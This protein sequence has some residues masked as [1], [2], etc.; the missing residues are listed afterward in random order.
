ME[1]ISTG[2]ESSSG[3]IPAAVS[4]PSELRGRLILATIM[5]LTYATD[6]VN[7]WNTARA[8]RFVMVVVVLDILSLCQQCWLNFTALRQLISCKVR[9][10]GRSFPLCIQRFFDSLTKDQSRW[11]MVV[12]NPGS[13]DHLK[14]R[15][16]KLP[17]LV[18]FIRLPPFAGGLRG[19]RAKYQSKTS[20]A[21]RTKYDLEPH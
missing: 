9:F 2:S 20:Q 5:L 6:G 18:P 13:T 1:D 3:V 19:C 12:P 4:H 17:R 21:S 16:D 15:Y 10:S 7:A 14:N 11:L 8:Q